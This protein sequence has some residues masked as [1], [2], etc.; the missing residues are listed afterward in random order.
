MDRLEE[1][2]EK[3]QNYMEEKRKTQ[4]Q[5]TEIETQRAEV[6]Q[7]R[8]FKKGLNRVFKSEDIKSEIDELGKEISNLGNESQTLQKQIDSKLVEIKSQL[9]IEL[10]NLIAEDIRK[11]RIIDEQIQEI[12]ASNVE[13]K[14]RTSKYQSQKQEFFVRFGRIPELSQEAV[15][16]WEKQQKKYESNLR[17]IAR[18]KNNRQ[19][20][21]GSILE[22]STLQK[23]IR[24]GEIY[25]FIATE[26]Q[27][28]PKVE[29]YSQVG[30]G[31]VQEAKQDE[32]IQ[33]EDFVPQEEQPIEELNIEDFKPV[34]E[35]HIEEFKPVEEPKIEEFKPVEGPDIEEL[36]VE[37]FK[38]VEEPKIE[39]FKPVEG[40]NI[41]ELHVE[42]FK[43]AEEFKP[44]EEIKIEGFEPVG[45]IH[46]K[47][48]DS[49]KENQVVNFA[50]TEETQQTEEPKTEKFVEWSTTGDID[51]AESKRIDPLKEQEIITFEDNKIISKNKETNKSL[52]LTLQN[53]VV[54]IEDGELVYKAQISNG[55][56]ITKYPCKE[57]ILVGD[58]GIRPKIAARVAKYAL[59]RYKNFDRKV[60]KKLDPIICKIIEEFG[61]KY[62]QDTNKLIYN[63]AMSFS[64]IGIIEPNLL[65]EI[66]YNLSYIKEAKMSKEEQKTIEKISRNA[67]RNSKI[68]TIGVTT[69]IDKIKYFLRKI[70]N[71]NKANT[72]PEGNIKN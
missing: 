1:I 30:E 51:E 17:E 35:I 46:V 28:S 20:I 18:L 2:K 31:K 54:K 67:N 32:E 42:E 24:H 62:N 65:P 6:A 9:S 44:F 53:I 47:E 72:L 60:I 10:N 36:H 68:D 48:P 5:I 22:L 19:K 59:S 66:I 3:L 16:E 29:E 61:E 70:F 52:P 33:V 12:M 11:T 7:D 26:Q 15:Q 37:E 63:Y 43:P 23:D 27:T 56:T 14:E 58:Y 13:Q 39:E 25:G 69:K 55:E 64:K 4:Q 57:N 45:K 49:D 50:S 34:E 41:E 38:P 71:I 40:P 21:E 8:N